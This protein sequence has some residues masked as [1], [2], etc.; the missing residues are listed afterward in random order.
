MLGNRQRSLTIGRGIASVA[1][2]PAILR[3][4]D[5]FGDLTTEELSRLSIPCS[6]F[7]VIEDGVLFKQG[8]EASYVY[9]LSMG[10]IALQKS[11]RV[12]HGRRSRRTTIAVRVR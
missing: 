11:I 3:D 7:V 2:R 9:L 1:S 8:R 4:S 12:P 6:D 5:L 10:Q